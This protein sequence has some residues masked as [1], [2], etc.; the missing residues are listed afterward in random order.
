MLV[1]NDNASFSPWGY[2]DELV[3][4]VGS[5]AEGVVLNNDGY[6]DYPELFAHQVS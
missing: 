3:L 1:V 5:V 6:D 2:N 4:A